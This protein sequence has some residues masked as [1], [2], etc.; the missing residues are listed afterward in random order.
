MQRVP[1]LTGAALNGP[2]FFCVKTL[3]VPLGLA[4]TGSIEWFNSKIR[5]Q[6]NTA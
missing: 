3:N 5:S 1:Q 6:P 4:P 2:P